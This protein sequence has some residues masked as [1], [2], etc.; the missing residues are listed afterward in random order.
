MHPPGTWR[1][2][3][4][5]YS[6]RSRKTAVRAGKS[7]ACCVLCDLGSRFCGVFSDRRVSWKLARSLQTGEATTSNG[8]VQMYRLF[9]VFS[10]FIFSE[11]QRKGSFILNDR[12]S[13]D[14][15][16]LG[17]GGSL[18]HFTWR[19]SLIWSLAPQNVEVCAGCC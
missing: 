5:V 1:R 15:P 17:G 8:V 13:S 11:R 18:Q 19:K 4:F 2:A 9:F 3:A 16:P 6:P 14:P 10:S 7:R 12:C